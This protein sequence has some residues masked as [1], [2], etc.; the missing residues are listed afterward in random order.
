MIE[1]YGKSIE[2]LMPFKNNFF[3]DN[4]KLLNGILEISKIY[5]QQPLRNGCKNCGSLFCNTEISFKKQN[6]RYVVCKQCGHCNGDKNETS[7]FLCSI[8][9]KQ[10]GKKYAENYSEKDVKT[11]WERVKSIYTPKVDFLFDVLSA[12]DENPK[13][14]SYTDV[15]AGSGYFVAALKK[16]KVSAAIGYDVSIQQSNVAKAMIGEEAVI[17]HEIGDIEVVCENIQSSV[18]SMIGV[19]EHVKNPHKVMKAIIENKNINYLFM[20][21]PLFG[22][23]VLVESL[24]EDV[25][26]RHLAGGHTHVFSVESLKYFENHHSLLPIGRWWFGADVMD[27]YRSLMIQSSKKRNKALFDLFDDNLRG[28]IDDMQL[29]MDQKKFCSS[30]HVVYQISR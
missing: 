20:T 13:N 2:A 24:F 6:V 26:P 15:G 18:V 28:C 9:N 1:K 12:N 10:D 11:Y 16:A 7:S 4:N 3:K 14:I 25:M 22:F 5:N 30:V 17:T 21:Y 27:L 23:S 8:Y 19:I 29:V